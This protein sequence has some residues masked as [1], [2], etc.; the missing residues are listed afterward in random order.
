MTS[1]RSALFRINALW[2]LLTLGLCATI[3]VLTL[4]PQAPKPQNW[5]VPD[6]IYHAVAFA[7]L[8]LPTTL[9][10]PDR[11]LWTALVAVLY[12]GLIEVIQS[13]VGRSP[14]LADVMADAIGVAF[15]AGAGIALRSLLPKSLNS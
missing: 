7:G 14:E 5:P 8:I 10:R 13:Q 3:A 11:L 4:M 2:L 1:T 6:K 15:G 9:L 12:G